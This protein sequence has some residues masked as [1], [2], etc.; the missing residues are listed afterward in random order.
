MDRTSLYDDD[1]YAWA[2]QQAAALRRVAATRTDLP[3]ELDLDH[4]AE[5]IGDL[6]KSELHA[7]TSF[8]F[9]ALEHLAKL[10][11]DPGSQASVHW[12]GE[13]G[14][15]LRDAGK[16]YSPGMRRIIDLD[17]AW[18]DGVRLACADLRRYGLEFVPDYPKTC[19]FSLDELLNEDFDVEAAVGRLRSLSG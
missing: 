19:P 12:S 15:F 13:V 8:L 3:N 6:G 2:E 4:I 5:E 18:R 14:R 17:E 16:A 7:T 11:G 1:I 10:A 9:R